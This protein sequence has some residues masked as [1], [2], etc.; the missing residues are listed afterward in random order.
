MGRVDSAWAVGAAA[1]SFAWRLRG[2]R[3]NA[4]PSPGAGREGRDAGPGNEDGDAERADGR[5]DGR[6]RDAE[7]PA[8]LFLRRAARMRSAETGPFWQQRTRRLVGTAAGRTAGLVAGAS[9]V[10][11][12]C[13]RVRV[14][15]F[16]VA[17]GPCVPCAFVHN[18]AGRA[19]ATRPAAHRA[20]APRQRAALVH[21]GAHV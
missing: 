5:A 8:G 18:R 9:R 14:V 16:D 13:G 12:V 7:T 4:Y 3:S 21:P 1:P 20:S 10:G 19:S 17:S 11:W 15:H 6:R 2:A